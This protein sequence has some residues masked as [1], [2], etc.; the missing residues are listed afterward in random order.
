MK[1]CAMAKQSYRLALMEYLATPLDSN[2]PSPSELNGH[3]FNS[4]LPNISTFSRHSDVLVSHHNAQLQC[5]KRGHTLPEL[6]VGTKVGCRNHVTNKFEVG[7]NSARDARLYTIHTEN[8]IHVSRNH[9]DLKWTDA[10]FESKTKTQPF[11]SSNAKSK[12][13]PTTPVPSSTNVKCTDKAKLIVKRVEVRKPNSM[14][15][16]CSGRISKPAIRLITQ[17]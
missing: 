6:P 17:M 12:H 9:I 10:P 11:V 15:T 13:A 3:R 5:D 1:H 14:Y 2:T 4:L 8:G 16:T 7:I